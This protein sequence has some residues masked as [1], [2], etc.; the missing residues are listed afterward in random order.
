MNVLKNRAREYLWPNRKKLEAIVIIGSVLLLVLYYFFDYSEFISFGVEE[1]ILILS[2]FIILFLEGMATE[3]NRAT[4]QIRSDVSL[5]P[6]QGS[7]PELKQ[8][9]SDYIKDR[10]PNEVKMIEYSSST[11]DAIIE[12]AILEGAEIKLLLKH[13]D[14]T[15]P[16]NQ[17][18]KI[19]NQVKTLHS[20]LSASENIKIR[21][22]KPPATIRGRKFDDD[23][24]N[25]GWYTYQS[26]DERGVHLKGHINPTVLVSAD[27]G[28]EYQ[29]I[30]QMFDRM[31]ENLWMNATT[32][33]ELYEQGD[34]INDAT[35]SFRRWV[36][37]K[38]CEDWIRAVSDG[39]IHTS[40]S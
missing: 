14:S 4:N 28:E 18:D 8:V 35:G 2:I 27:E 32:L 3:I 23:L 15:I 36:D 16:D 17:P 30:Q 10:R 13:P 25:C 22:Y 33:E 6:D 20:D 37:T 39:K 12:D 11:V 40:Q 1:N 31:F 34:D 29:Y 19:L 9:L 7:T 21:F 38:G 26:S 24:I 5:L